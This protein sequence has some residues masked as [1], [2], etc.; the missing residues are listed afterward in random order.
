MGLKKTPTEG[1]SGGNR[2]HSNMEHWAFTDEVKDAARAQRRIEDQKSIREGT[3]QSDPAIEPV[4]WWLMDSLPDLNW[5][6][7]TVLS[8]G[9][10][11]VFDCDGTTHRFPT[12]LDA[13]HFLLEDEFR[14]WSSFDASDFKDE[15]ISIDQVHPP[16]GNDD[17][18][19]LPQMLQRHP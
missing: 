7:L 3:D 12:T 16:E 14:P 17:E 19:L 8:N 4:E 2:G 18:T 15:P 13:R 9:H 1:G 10:A 6:R 5:A 11:E